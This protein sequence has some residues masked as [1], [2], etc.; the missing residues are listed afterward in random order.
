MCAARCGRCL[1]LGLAVLLAGC[2]WVKPSMPT[3]IAFRQS[4]IN[5][6]RVAQFRNVSDKYLVARLEVRNPTLGT[7][8][9]RSVDLPPDMLVEVGWLQGCRL[10]TGDRLIL[11]H[12]DFRSLRVTVP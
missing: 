12:A 9:C 3:E 1:A 10:A 6:G 2:D 4:L 11:R 7:V 8:T 5:Y